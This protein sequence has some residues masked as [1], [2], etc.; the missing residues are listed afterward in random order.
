MEGEREGRHPPPAPLRVFRGHVGTE[1]LG[2]CVHL[3]AFLFQQ[4]RSD[5]NLRVSFNSI[6]VSAER[7]L[8]GQHLA[9]TDP[10]AGRLIDRSISGLEQGR[11]RKNLTPASLSVVLH[12]QC[13]AS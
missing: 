8:L 5:K 4:S 12:Q 9:C 3:D 10:V 7:S 13:G 11:D 6:E 2:I 1:S